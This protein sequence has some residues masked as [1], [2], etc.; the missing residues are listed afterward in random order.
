MFKHNKNE[1]LL[2][3]TGKQ[4]IY[5]HTYKIVIYYMTERY[6]DKCNRL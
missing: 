1:K 3:C 5:I 4:V 2:Y 6:N